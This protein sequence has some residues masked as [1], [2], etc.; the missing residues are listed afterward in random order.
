MQNHGI[1]FLNF[2]RIPDIAH[3]SV[4]CDIEGLT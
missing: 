1:V 3:Y 4:I 2:C